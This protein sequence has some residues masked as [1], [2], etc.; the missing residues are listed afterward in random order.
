[1]A[2]E[3]RRKQQSASRRAF[4]TEVVVATA[5]N[6]A[7]AEM[8]CIRLANAGI[9]AEARRSIGGPEWGWAGA[10]YI[11]VEPDAVATAKEILGAPS[12]F[13]EDDLARLSEASAAGSEVRLAER[14]AA[15]PP[16]AAPAPKHGAW[17][18][19]LRLM[20]GG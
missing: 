16:G 2:K 9:A 17:A 4:G 15:M 20:R 1:M 19:L 7:E 5:A 8:I 11:Y 3:D 13:G 10:R 12:G 18:K 6:Q 14:D